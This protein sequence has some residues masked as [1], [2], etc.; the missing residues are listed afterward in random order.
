MA[1]TRCGWLPV[2]NKKK[3]VYE[4]KLF[5]MIHNSF[6]RD[7]FFKCENQIVLIKT[8]FLC[9][10]TRSLIMLIALRFKC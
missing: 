7:T 9:V 8:I 3:N 1:I 2:I 10:A 6:C 4:T 5:N